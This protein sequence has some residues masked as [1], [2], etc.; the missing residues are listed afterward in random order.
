MRTVRPLLFLSALVCVA[1][2]MLFAGSTGKI[3]GRV[4]DAKSKEPLPGANVM[5]EG[6]TLGATTDV[7]GNFVILNVPPGRYALV[8]SFVGY[9]RVRMENIRI[10]VDFTTTADIA[11][12]PGDIRMAEVVVR[13]ER[14]PLIRKD[15]TNPVTAISSETFNELPVTEISELIGLQAGIT[16]N[17]DGTIHIRGGYDNEVAYT[18]NGI[19]VNNPYGNRR[20]VGLATN[21]VQ[22]VSVSGGTFSAEYG[23]ALSGVVN[24]VTKEGGRNWGGSFK[25]FGGDNISSHTDLFTNIDNVKP[26]NTFRFEGSLGGPLIGDDLT[27]FGSGVYNFSGGYRYARRTYRPEDAYLSREGFPTGDPRRGSSTGPYYFGPLTH[28]TSN[29]VG[30]PSGDGELVALDWSRSYNIQGNLSFRVSQ[31]IHIK[32]EIVKDYS[33]QPSG[34]SFPSVQS[35]QAYWFKPDGHA[36]ETDNGQ[37]QS[38]EVTHVL[39]DRM[40]Y[41]LKG[42]YITDEVTSW[43]YDDPNDPRYLPT[44]Y[45]VAIPNTVYLT[46]GVDLGRFQRKTITQG[47]KFDIIAQLFGIHEMKAGAEYRQHDLT[48]ESYTLQFKD[49][50]PGNE[51]LTP[52][53]SN[54]ITKGANFLPYIP[55]PAGGYVNYDRTPKEFGAYI[56]DKIELFKSIILNV[57]VRYDY[58]DAAANYNPDISQQLV[59]QD[60]IFLLKN[61]QAASPKHMVSPRLSVSYPITDRGTIRLSY[62]H[63]Y[64]VGSL[65]SLYS[66]PNYRAPLGA[67]NPSFGNPNVNPQKGIQYEIGLQQGFTDD[68]KIEVTGYY[69]D[70]RDYIYQQTIITPRGD[71]QYSLLT[72]LSY[73]NTRGLSISLLK[74]RSPDGMLSATLDYTYQIADGNRTQPTEELF[75][76]E[77]KGQLSETYLV[78]LDFDRSHTLTSTVT[79]TDP[80]NWI[81]ST[82]LYLRTGTPYTASF[83]SSVVPILFQQN[84]DRQPV[85]WNVDLK[86]EKFF[87]LGSLRLSVFALVDNLFDREN[88]LFVY[89]NSGKALYNIEQ[90]TNPTRFTDLRSRINRGDPGMI[91]V[92]SVDNYYA[93][94]GNISAPRLVRAGISVLF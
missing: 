66:N 85:Q 53:F 19:N 44:Y 2:G 52:S 84:S 71:R 27:I 91:P 20:S 61:L 60:S 92:S 30:G 16:V 57:G 23:K 34:T 75:F 62:G 4:T 54:V 33:R 18:L 26:N 7:D 25:Y 29:T 36:M 81:V 28:D 70:I 3:S 88:E 32:Y 90:T 38:I 86:A 58:F 47:L 64:Q 59:V 74:R 37:F 39:S 17:D 15:L 68:L 55:T 50:T 73:A 72:N 1:A 63:F 80:D 21:A 13:S 11:L 78:P 51:N 42:S 45:G 6:T 40:F 46:G 79:L 77:Q 24:Y 14:S 94:P 8:A 41:T 87:N 67:S 43:A 83:P 65:S 12:E 76:S 35:S 93:N 22:E 9:Q 56:Q 82:I 69:K 5:V 89:G 49:P 10:S 31:D 48:V